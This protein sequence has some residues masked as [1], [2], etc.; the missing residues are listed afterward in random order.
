[1]HR[2]EL[3]PLFSKVKKGATVVVEPAETELLELGRLPPST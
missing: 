2:P 3:E 1:M